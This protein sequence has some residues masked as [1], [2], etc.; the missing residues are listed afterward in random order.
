M[1]HALVFGGTGMLAGATK[2]LIENAE[3]VSVVGRNKYKLEQLRPEYTNNNFQLV[4]LDYKDSKALREFLQQTIR[5]YGPVDL[6]V[7]WIHSTS[8]DAIPLILGELQHQKNPWRFIHIKGS[9]HNLSGITNE[10]TVPNNCVYGDVQLGFKIEGSTSRWLTH[11]E[12]S[13]G[14]ISAIR[15]NKRKTVIGTLHPW[16]KRP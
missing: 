4:T 8:P 14:V 7:S 1:T 9:S 13:N 5:V 15:H 16:S 10:I 6:V 11:E 2:W 3:H 12:I